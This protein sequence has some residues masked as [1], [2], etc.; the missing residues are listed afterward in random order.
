VWCAQEGNGL[1]QVVTNGRKKSPSLGKIGPNDIRKFR[2]ILYATGMI[3]LQFVHYTKVVSAA[4]L[5]FLLTHWCGAL[6]KPNAL[7][8]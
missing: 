6:M 5:T 7:S 2:S 8:R 3:F 1:V 4:A